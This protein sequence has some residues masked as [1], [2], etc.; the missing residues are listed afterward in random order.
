M[1]TGTGASSCLLGTD[2][3]DLLVGEGPYGKQHDVLEE[4]V[5]SKMTHVQ[6]S[7]IAAV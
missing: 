4:A 1:L 5:A 6:K 2:R 3:T 7:S